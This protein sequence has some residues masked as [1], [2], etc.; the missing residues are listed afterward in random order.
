MFRAIDSFLAL[1]YIW[2][3]ISFPRVS[4]MGDKT[5]E[6]NRGRNRDGSQRLVRILAISCIQLTPPLQP[7]L[8]LLPELE[9]KRMAFMI[10]Y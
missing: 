5:G 8:M 7:S 9:K 2:L 4:G 1:N 3:I 10:Q 6:R